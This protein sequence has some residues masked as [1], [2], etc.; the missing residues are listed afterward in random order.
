MSNKRNI[1]LVVRVLLLSDSM[2]FKDLYT[3]FSESLVARSYYLSCDVPHIVLPGSTK[4]TT[5][6]QRSMVNAMCR[7]NE[8]L[9]ER[10]EN[11]KRNEKLEKNETQRW[12]QS[13]AT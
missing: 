11:H 10:R 7:G 3:K 1:K 9:A 2:T 6:P 13:I 8:I 5:R 4:T 12:S